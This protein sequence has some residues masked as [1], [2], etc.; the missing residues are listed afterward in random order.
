MVRA[1]DWASSGTRCKLHPTNMIANAQR[2]PDRQPVTIVVG[3]YVNVISYSHCREY[4]LRTTVSSWAKNGH[5]ASVS[6]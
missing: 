4:A 5:S 1:D 2:V 3:H 6:V